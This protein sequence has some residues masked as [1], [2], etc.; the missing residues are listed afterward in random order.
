MMKVDL[1]GPDRIIIGEVKVSNRA[2]AKLRILYGEPIQ[3]FF[4]AYLS[5]KSF[6][7]CAALV[8]DDIQNGIEKAFQ[9][10]IEERFGV[11]PELS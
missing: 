4:D 8:E 6:I 1:G 5:H 9:A 7:F 3:K 11:K 2:K 10:F